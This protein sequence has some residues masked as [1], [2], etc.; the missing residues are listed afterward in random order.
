MC[1]LYGRWLY[2]RRYLITLYVPVDSVPV[3]QCNTGY[4]ISGPSISCLAGTLTPSTAQ[5]CAPNPCTV[6]AP[7]GGTLTGNCVNGTLAS[8]LSCTVAC[9]TGYTPV[10]ATTIDGGVAQL[11]P[12]VQCEHLHSD[13]ADLWLARL[14]LGHFG[15]G[16][17]LQRHMQRTSC[18]LSACAHGVLWA[19]SHSRSMLVALCTACVAWLC[20]RRQ[21]DNVYLWLAECHPGLRGQAVHAVCACRWRPCRRCQLWRHSGARFQLPDEVQRRLHAVGCPSADEL[22]GR[23]GDRA[24]MCSG[25]VHRR[26]ARRR[27]YRHLRRSGHQQ[28]HLLLHPMRFGTPTRTRLACGS[29]EGKLR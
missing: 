4:T 15:V 3:C 8:G 6:T 7:V 20:A 25:P 17:L 29:G 23:H 16:I 10:G 2:G 11:R 1:W 18:L 28:R 24:V 21:C 9:A 12:A 26:R 14:L 5:T 27:E 13:S 19:W 22:L